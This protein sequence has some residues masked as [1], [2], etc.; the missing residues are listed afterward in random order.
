MASGLL[1]KEG[2]KVMETNGQPR[3]R[4]ASGINA[5]NQMAKMDKIAAMTGLL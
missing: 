4:L 1:G 3:V 2:R 5:I